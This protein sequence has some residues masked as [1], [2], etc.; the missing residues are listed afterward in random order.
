MGYS[1]FLHSNQSRIP[2]T[3]LPDIQG[4]KSIRSLAIPKV[5]IRE[6]KVPI[7]LIG[8]GNQHTQASIWSDEKQTVEGSCSVYVNLDE[9]TKGIN[10]SRLAIAVHEAAKEE[11]I[12]VE[13]LANVL[14]RLHATHPDS[15]DVYIKVRFNYRIN[16]RSPFTS[17]WGYSYIPITIEAISNNQGQAFYQTVKVQFIA[18]CPCSKELSIHSYEQDGVP[19]SP[20]Q[21]RGFATVTVPV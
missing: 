14:Q 13:F 12:A 11:E 8:R 4:T 9:G 1:T 10:M 7:Q 16:K 20:H 19:A 18:T 17:N 3:E 15:K 6:I 2:L 5:G 21:Q